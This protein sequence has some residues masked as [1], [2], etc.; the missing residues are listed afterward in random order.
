MIGGSNLLTGTVHGPV[1]VQVLSGCIPPPQRPAYDVVWVV[2]SRMGGEASQVLAG[3][4]LVSLGSV[5]LDRLLGS[6]RDLLVWSRALCR[7]AFAA[8]N[9]VIGNN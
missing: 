7:D 1:L 9:K 8:A 3:T 4:Y 2:W 6:H 5:V